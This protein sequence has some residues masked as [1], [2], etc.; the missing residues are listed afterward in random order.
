VIDTG[1]PLVGQETIGESAETPGA[2]RHWLASYYPVRAAAGEILGIGAVVSEVTERRRAERLA[3]A[4]LEAARILAES[5]TV[6]DA[7]P[8]ILEGVCESLGW[9]GAELW[10][11]HG[12]ESVVRCTEAWHG[13]SLAGVELDAEARLLAFGASEGLRGGVWTTGEADATGAGVAPPA[14]DEREAGTSPATTAAAEP[15]ASSRE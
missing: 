13:P 10:R 12:D 1:E 15:E 3:A 9:E 6:E 11:V 14:E 4:Q 7:V 8:R 2:L 5:A